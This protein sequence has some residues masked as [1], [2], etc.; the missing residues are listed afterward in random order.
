MTKKA[1]KPQPQLPPPP[2]AGAL[3]KARFLG[4]LVGLLPIVGMLLMFRNLVPQ[5]LALMLTMAGLYFSV[6]LQ[7]A[8][9]QRFAYD[10]K[11]REE[12]LALGVY[13]ALLVAL[14]VGAFYWQ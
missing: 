13:V 5:W 4:Y 2:P 7:Q 8:A 3:F 6:Q 12:W 9:R 10:F 1:P 11:N 14:M